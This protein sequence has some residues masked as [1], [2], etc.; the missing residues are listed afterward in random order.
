[1][2]DREEYPEWLIDEVARVWW[3]AHETEY[4]FRY[5]KDRA[6]TTSG[7]YD[8]ILQAT[9]ESAKAVLDHL[10][11]RKNESRG[12][13]KNGI[14]YGVFPPGSGNHY[15]RWDGRADWREVSE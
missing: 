1:M 4:D 10:N 11:F 8:E 9:R 12:H 5:L 3:D 14:V 7:D 15:E 6:A 13:L 2:T